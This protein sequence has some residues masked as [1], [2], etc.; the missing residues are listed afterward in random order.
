MREPE[1]EYMSDLTIRLALDV[2]FI[3]I[4]LVR[5]ASMWFVTGWQ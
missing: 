2:C 4:L 1:F 5:T 3:E